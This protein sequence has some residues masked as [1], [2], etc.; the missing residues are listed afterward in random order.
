MLKVDE[1][2]ETLLENS[3]PLVGEESVALI[4]ANGRT[5]AEDVVA[6]LDVPPA[7]NSAMDGYALRHADRLDSQ[8]ALPL[9][10]RITAGSVPGELA[11]GTAARIFTGAEVPAGADTVVMQEHCEGDAS[12]VTAC[13]KPSWF[14]RSAGRADCLNTGASPSTSP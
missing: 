10:Q 11:P 2:I 13:W 5:L 1:A 7:D 8:T 4:D 12:R 6:E 14:S 3:K 9:S